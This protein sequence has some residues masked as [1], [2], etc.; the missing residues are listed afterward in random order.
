MGF[1]RV[2]AD[3]QLVSDFRIALSGGQALEN[4]ALARTQRPGQGGLW[5]VGTFFQEEQKQAGL[6]G[7]GQANRHFPLLMSQFQL[8]GRVRPGF[9]AL[10]MAQFALDPV[11]QVP[12]QAGGRRA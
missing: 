3:V 1:D 9:R 12:M 4:L 7:V 11:E 2:N 6:W 10:A 5:Q 8:T